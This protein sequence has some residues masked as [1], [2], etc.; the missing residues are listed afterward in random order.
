MKKYIFGLI[1]VLLVVLFLFGSAF[2]F[3]VSEG[4][5]AY[6][7]RFGKVGDEA[8]FAPGLHFK[9][10]F[11]DV[12]RVDKRIQVWDG[13]P[14]QIST[15]DKR[16]I[17]VDTTARWK[18]EDPKIFVKQV[19]NISLAQGRLDDII[20]S[21]V[22]DEVSSNYLDDLVGGDNRQPSN[23]SDLTNRESSLVDLENDGTRKEKRDRQEILNRIYAKASERVKSFGIDLIDV[24]IRRIIYIDDVCKK[25]Y[26]RMIAERNKV[27]AAYRS[28]GEGKAAE[29]RGQMN[30]ELKKISSEAELKVAQIRGEAD[31]EAAAVYANAYSTDP[32]FYA[33][34]RSMQGLEKIINGK[35][36]LILSTDSPIFKYLNKTN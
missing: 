17:F 18:I 12:V 32:E 21:A 33:F 28:E 36:K 24:Q 31:A 4:E 34:Y 15:K 26:E 19:V 13:D 11:D 23:E 8:P 35:N 9:T 3:T 1:F 27:A 7:T 20:D 30:R 29:I 5:W 16:Y 14:N 25:V 2:M 22:R 6:L 10:P